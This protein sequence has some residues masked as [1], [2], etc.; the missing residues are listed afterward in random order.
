MDRSSTQNFSRACALICDKR[1]I[2]LVPYL[3]LETGKMVSGNPLAGGHQ[4]LIVDR[5]HRFSP[6]N[7][8]PGIFVIGNRPCGPNL[9]N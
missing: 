7:F 5:S 1:R 2:L 4:P 8:R 9:L 3:P 6:A